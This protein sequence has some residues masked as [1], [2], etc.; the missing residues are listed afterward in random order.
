MAPGH[1]SGFCY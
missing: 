1:L